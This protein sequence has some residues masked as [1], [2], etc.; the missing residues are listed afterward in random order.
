M[1]AKLGI[2][3]AH[4]GGFSA[5]LRQLEQYPLPPKSNVLEVGCGTGRTAC[6]LAAQ[7]HRVTGVDIRPDMIGKANMRADKERVSVQFMEGDASA[8]PFQNDSFDVILAESVSVFTDTEKALKEYHRVLCKDGKLYDRE[9]VQRNPMPR[10]IYDEI[11]QFYQINTLWDLATWSS[12]ISKA[13]FRQMQVDGPFLFP[14]VDEDLL[15]HPDH[16]QQIDDGSFFDQKIWTLTNQYNRI[17]DL[18]QEFIGFI[19]IIGTK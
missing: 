7:G 11:M 10:D 16:Y 2:G 6:Y 8:L 4:P 5:T 19:L 9:M 15:K 17:M 12:L 18:S 1:L 13:G 3:N 14:Q